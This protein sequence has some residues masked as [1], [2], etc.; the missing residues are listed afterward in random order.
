MISEKDTKPAKLVRRPADESKTAL[1][2]RT[3]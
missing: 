1:R 3:L 2:L